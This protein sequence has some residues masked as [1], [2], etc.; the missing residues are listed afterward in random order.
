MNFPKDIEEFVVQT[1]GEA[2]V[3][4]VMEILECA[5]L[6]DGE[7]PNHRQI[8]CAL[9]ASGG[10]LEGLMWGV[11]TL[12]VDFRDVIVAGEYETKNGEL[13]RVRDLSSPIPAETN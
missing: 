13:V 3:T 5:A 4:D 10:S 6:H 9:V 11:E 7:P 2:L 8:R 12:A 1:F